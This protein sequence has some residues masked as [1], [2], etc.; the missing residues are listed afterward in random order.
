VNERLFSARA[1]RVTSADE[2]WEGKDCQGSTYSDTD[3]YP[4]GHFEFNGHVIRTIGRLLCRAN[5]HADL[6][7]LL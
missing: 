4:I 3:W 5:D 1:Q 2:L 7:E 6:A